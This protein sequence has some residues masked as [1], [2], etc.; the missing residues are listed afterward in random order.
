MAYRQR[1]L[2]PEEY[3][4]ILTKALKLTI[5]MFDQIDLAKWPLNEN[6]IIILSGMANVYHFVKDREKDMNSHFPRNCPVICNQDGRIITLWQCPNFYHYLMVNI[7]PNSVYCS[8]FNTSYNLCG[9]YYIFLWMN[10]IKLQRWK[11]AQKYSISGQKPGRE[12]G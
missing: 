8:L 9:T 10:C 6:E 7:H 12:E 3:I 5:P 2:A 11:I 1:N 4:E